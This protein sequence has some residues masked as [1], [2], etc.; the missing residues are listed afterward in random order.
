MD[1]E[2][3]VL[4][5]PVWVKYWSPSH[6]NSSPLLSFAHL[7]VSLTYMVMIIIMVIGVQ[8]HNDHGDGD[9]HSGD[10][11]EDVFD[12]YDYQDFSG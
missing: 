5:E 2:L 11:E 1:I 10:G 7:V 6:S 8:G 12:N 3:S 4:W 9:D